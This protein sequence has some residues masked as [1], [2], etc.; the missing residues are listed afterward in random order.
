MKQSQLQGSR[1]GGLWTNL[2]KHGGVGT[3][4]AAAAAHSRLCHSLAPQ[5]VQLHVSAGVKLP[6]CSAAQLSDLTQEPLDSHLPLP[7]SAH[8]GLFSTGASS[9]ELGHG[10]IQGRR[11]EQP[12]LPQ[13][14]LEG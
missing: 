8:P 2:H 7:P 14:C 9:R 1:S 4:D 5:A 13:G 3:Q 11:V 12:H 10:E 6:V